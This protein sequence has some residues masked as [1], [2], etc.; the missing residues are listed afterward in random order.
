MSSIKRTFEVSVIQLEF[1]LVLQK[2]LV[3]EPSKRTGREILAIKTLHISEKFSKMLF[4][5]R[6]PF[7]LVSIVIFFLEMPLRWLTLH[8]EINVRV[9]CFG[10]F[11]FSLVCWLS[12]SS[13]P[14]ILDLTVYILIIPRHLN[15]TFS[16]HGL[17]FL[18]LPLILIVWERSFLLPAEP[19]FL[20]PSRTE[21]LYPHSAFLLQKFLRQRWK[22]LNFLNI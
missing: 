5:N 7:G 4:K 2:I 11:K 18:A 9:F 19:A 20:F 22:S 1:L 16:N 15:G 21:P 12:L 8:L 6:H 17:N 3:H 14:K 13:L 10:F